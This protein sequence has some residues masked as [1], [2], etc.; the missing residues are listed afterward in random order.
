MKFSPTRTYPKIAIL[1][2]DIHDIERTGPVPG[3]SATNFIH[4]AAMHKKV[5]IANSK[6]STY[7]P[8]NQLKTLMG[9][10]FAWD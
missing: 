9:E 3:P 6:P 2:P 4:N 7:R 5:S 10:I 1:S 8:V